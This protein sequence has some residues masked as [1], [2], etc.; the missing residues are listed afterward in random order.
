M[1]FAVL[2]QTGHSTLEYDLDKSD[3]VAAAMAKF[4]ELVNEKKYG[5]AKRDEKTGQLVKVKA[6][7]PTA[8]EIVM[9]PHL[10]GG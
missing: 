3:E 9:H 10:V 6:F 1:R 5:A 4:D 2:D 8:D 7:D